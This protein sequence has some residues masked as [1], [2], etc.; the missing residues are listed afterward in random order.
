MGAIAY[1]SAS[2]AFGLIMLMSYLFQVTIDATTQHAS[3]LANAML[4]SR[5]YAAR[6]VDPTYTG[7]ID[8]YSIVPSIHHSYIER[9]SGYAS[10]GT[11]YIYTSESNPF[12]LETLS[13]LSDWSLS[14]GR[15]GDNATGSGA[16]I[17]PPAVACQQVISHGHCNV[18]APSVLPLNSVVAVSGNT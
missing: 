18:P 2:V 10:A 1:G 16:V 11:V 13:E 9:V 12:L 6:S 5:F 15:V 3:A 17:T 7:S 4:Q 14:I 8:L